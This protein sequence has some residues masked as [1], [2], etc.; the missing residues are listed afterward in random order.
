M[1]A[2]AETVLDELTPIANYMAAEMNRNARGEIARKIA[3]LNDY[4]IEDCVKDYQD[5][6]V[7]GKL[8]G[9]GMQMDSCIK[10]TTT[11]AQA[12]LLEWTIMVR[13]GGPWDHKV[14]IPKMFHP[15]DPVAQ[16]W[17]AYG[18]T[19]Y[20]YDVWSNIHYGYVGRACGFSESTL[21]DGA[22]LEQIGS[23]IVR[24]KMPKKTAKTGGAR[25]YDD[26]SDRVAIKMGILLF[27]QTPRGVTAQQLVNM[28]LNS[29]D[30]TQ[31]AR[32]TDGN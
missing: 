16:H 21:L 10:N 24:G 28:I 32:A 30:I 7:W 26:I 13:Q 15:R 2:N 8:L 27:K 29:K 22:G 14:I 1:S 6:S 19:A 31:K 20:F 11:F 4:S 17:H 3:R 25:D 12:A 23:D 5:L 18:N 9:G